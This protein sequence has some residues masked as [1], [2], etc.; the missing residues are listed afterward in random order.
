LR[1]AAGKAAAA[2]D[3]AC[4]PPGVKPACYGTTT[5]FGW[6]Q[7]IETYFDNHEYATHCG[8]PSGAFLD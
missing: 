3:K 5:G 6:V 2:I 7:L 1:G 4:E 8:S